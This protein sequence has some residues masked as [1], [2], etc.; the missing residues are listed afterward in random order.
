MMSLQEHSQVSLKGQGVQ[1]EILRTGGCLCLLEG[2]EGGSGEL[3]VSQPPLSP[4]KVTSSLIA[5]TTI[6]RA[7]SA[8]FQTIHN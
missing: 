8:N 5:W 4:R 3:Q 7:P 2:Q 1:G 6:Q